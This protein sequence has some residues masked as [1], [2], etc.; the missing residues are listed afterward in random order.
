MLTAEAASN[1]KSLRDAEAIRLAQ[2]AIQVVGRHS[3]YSEQAAVIARRATAHDAA[4]KERTRMVGTDKSTTMPAAAAKKA[5]MLCLLE[6]DD[7]ERAA[8]LL[9]LAGDEPAFKANLPSASTPLE[10]LGEA[11]CWTL[12][13]WY[14]SLKAASRKGQATACRRAT[15]EYSRGFRHV[16]NHKDSRDAAAKLAIEQVSDELGAMEGSADGTLYG[17]ADTQLDLA[18]DAQVAISTGK[19][20]DVHDCK[21]RCMRAT[22]CARLQAGSNWG[23]AMFLKL[24]SGKAVAGTRLGAW[25]EYEPM[26]R[27]HGG[28]RHRERTKPCG[29][30]KKYNYGFLAEASKIKNPTCQAIWGTNKQAFRVS[31][32]DSG[33]TV[34][35]KIRARFLTTKTPRRWYNESRWHGGNEVAAGIA[36]A[37]RAGTPETGDGAP[38]TFGA[39]EPG[40]GTGA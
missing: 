8:K 17:N 11:D 13:Q 30:G 37:G 26:T 7:P 39:W 20:S 29:P 18:V 27:M 9:P 15:L 12:A 28:T 25:M 6:L 38:K 32:C 23:F 24:P 16:H 1:L 3:P 33:G 40:G 10:K 21:S 31:R 35:A 19:W 4:E 5:M 36:S 22:C 34:A 14:H 2:R